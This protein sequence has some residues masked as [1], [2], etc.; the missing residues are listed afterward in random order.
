MTDG[1]NQRRQSD[2]EKGLGPTKQ[3]LN[4]IRDGF[5]HHVVTAKYK[6]NLSP[7]SRRDDW[8]CSQISRRTTAQISSPAHNKTRS[9][10]HSTFFDALLNRIPDRRHHR[11]RRRPRGCQTRHWRRNSEVDLGGKEEG[12]SHSKRLMAARAGHYKNGT[13]LLP[14]PTERQEAKCAKETPT[15]TREGDI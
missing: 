11:Q 3:R 8:Y 1:G 4:K 12:E 9:L 13:K 14:P 10:V 2:V 15:T 7:Q 5:G 6:I